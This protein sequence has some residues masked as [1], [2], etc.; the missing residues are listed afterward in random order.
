MLNHILRKCE[1]LKEAVV[2]LEDVSQF[3]ESRGHIQAQSMLGSIIDK[4]AG[5]KAIT[6]GRPPFITFSRGL[7][8]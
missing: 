3:L 2:A 1:E 8:S 5:L 7:T 6:S 4:V